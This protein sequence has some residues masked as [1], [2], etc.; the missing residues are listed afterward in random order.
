[1]TIDERASLTA[2]ASAWSTPAVARGGI[3]EVFVT[4]GPAGARGP[5]FPGAG[6]QVRSLNIPCG[7]ALGATW[8][9]PLVE[10]LGAALGD[11]TRTKACRVLLA[12]TVNLHRAP[13]RAATSSRTRRIPCSPASSPRRSFAAC[14]PRVL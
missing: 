10:Q 14:S 9:P 11:Q 5:Q 6:Q 1:M 7:A 4:D 3:P 2:G 8:N 12:P 13:W